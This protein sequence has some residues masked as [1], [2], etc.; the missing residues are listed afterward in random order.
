MNHLD[1]PTENE[2]FNKYFQIKHLAE[3]DPFFFPRKFDKNESSIAKF[4]IKMI[5]RYRIL[6]D[7]SPTK[8]LYRYPLILV[9]EDC[10]LIDDVIFFSH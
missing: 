8:D 5:K 7:E 4:F 1:V 9:I 2:N 3:R 6:L 10:H